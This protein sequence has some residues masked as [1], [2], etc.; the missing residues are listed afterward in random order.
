MI[1]LLID[2]S[3]P[4]LQA[5]PK[6]TSIIVKLLNNRSASHFYLGNY[7]SALRDCQ[8]ALRADDN[9]VNLKVRFGDVGVSGL[10]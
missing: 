10:D 4:G 5:K 2:S 1:D 3:L 8:W 7:R 6:A 9:D